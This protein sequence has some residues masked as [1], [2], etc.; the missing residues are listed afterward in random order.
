[1]RCPKQLVSIVASEVSARS[2][3]GNLLLGVLRERPEA[4]LRGTAR[5][6]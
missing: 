2:A 3:N 5:R 1:M 6:P 4:H